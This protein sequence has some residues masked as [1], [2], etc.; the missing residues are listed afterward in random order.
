MK[1]HFLAE[2]MLLKILLLNEK[3]WVNPIF[4]E[5]EKC[6]EFHTLFPKLLEQPQKFYEYFR[7]NRDTFEYILNNIRPYIEK[8]SS[9]RKCISPEERLAVTLRQV[10]VVLLI[11]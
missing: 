9:F 11:H 10:S 8:Q 5:R 4:A 2:N 7:M 1:I 3:E 6:G